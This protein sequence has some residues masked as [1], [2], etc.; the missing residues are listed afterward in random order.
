MDN[1]IIATAVDRTMLTYT[2][3][4]LKG[5]EDQRQELRELVTAYIQG[6]IQAGQSDADLLVA[7]ALK[8]LV[9]L[10]DK[11]VRQDRDPLP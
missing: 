6:E 7:G 2:K 3:K 5:D 9:S 4:G 10:E 1:K 8:H 11:P